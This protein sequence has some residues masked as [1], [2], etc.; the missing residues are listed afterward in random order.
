MYSYALSLNYHCAEDPKW[1]E[2]VSRSKVRK[3]E[4]GAENAALL[5][6]VGA[7]AEDFASGAL[8]PVSCAILRVE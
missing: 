8:P 1:F 6:C 2:A 3:F 4:F 7:T 5:G